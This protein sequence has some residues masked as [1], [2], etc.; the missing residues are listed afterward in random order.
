MGMMGQGMGGMKVSMGQGMTAM[1]KDDFYKKF[2]V[3]LFWEIINNV[4]LPIWYGLFL[5]KIIGNKSQ[6][7]D[8][9]TFDCW[10]SPNSDEALLGVEAEGLDDYVNVTE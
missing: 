9:P 2:L 5:F 3:N 1:S 10:A 8:N 4:N 6:E 7:F